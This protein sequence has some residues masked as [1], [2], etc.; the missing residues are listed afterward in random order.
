MSAN[1]DDPALAA[2][3][4]DQ[5]LW[6]AR[7]AKSRSLAARLCVSGAVTVNGIP[8]RKANH[9]IRVGDRIVLTPGEWRRGVRILDLGQRRGPTAEACGLY[10]E[11]EAARRVPA[12]APEWIPLLAE[13]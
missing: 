11:I 3:R 9:V 13:E 2:R 6:F 4:L 5:W 1:G 10:E 7:F 8:V 12:P